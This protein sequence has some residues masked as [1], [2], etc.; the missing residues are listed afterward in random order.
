MRKLTFA[1]LLSLSLLTVT[2]AFAS[3]LP[4]VTSNE[5]TLNFPESATFRATITSDADITSVVLEYGNEQQTCGEV[6]AKAFPQFTSGKTVNAEWIWEMRQSGSLPPGAQLWWR[7]RVTDTNGNETITETETATWLDDVHNWQSMPNGENLQLYWY[8]G[9]Q[10][11]ITDLA[12]AASEGLVFNETQSGLKAEAPIDIYIY[13]NTDHL[14]EAILYEPS[15]TGGQAFPDQ[16]IVILGISESD[17]DWGRDAMVHELTHVLVGHLTFSC[18]GDVPTWLNEGLAVYSEGG[19]D[20]ASQRQLEDAIRDDTLLTVRSLSSGF[21]EVADKAY[22]SYSQSYS[23]TK[24]LIETY[25]QDKMTSLLMAL[26]GGVTIED[27]LI[28]TYGFNVDGLEDAW[29]AAIGAQ[30]RSVSTQ[31]TVQPSPTFVPT[32]V[33][34]GG[35]SLLAQVT[36][37]VVPTSSFGGQPTATPGRTGPP[38]ALTLILLGMCCIFLVLVG[39]V[40]LGFVV[41]SQNRKGG[42]NG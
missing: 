19:L 7:W 30:P 9:D 21:S 34:V 11:F 23:I 31:P 42:N 22:L 6:I 26:R 33:P 18:L 10:T 29:R 14:Q 5:V 39:V 3:P 24:F 27:A 35:T 17:F 37:T 38:L 41:R 25:G 15:W 32:I 2:S 28:Q 36:P 4:S 16:N 13:A 1:F 8:E 12:K 20:P 40:I